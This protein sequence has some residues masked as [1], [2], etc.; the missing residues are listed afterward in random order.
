M[1]RG[2]TNCSPCAVDPARGREQY[3]QDFLPGLGPCA[4]G[5]RLSAADSRFQGRSIRPR[6]FRRNCPLPECKRRAGRYVPGRIRF[7]GRARA[8]I[9]TK[10]RCQERRRLSLQYD[11]FPTQ[12]R[13]STNADTHRPYTRRSY[14]GM[15]RVPFSEQWSHASPC[16][17]PRRDMAKSRTR[18][19]GQYYGYRSKSVLALLEFVFTSRVTAWKS[20]IRVGFSRRL[21]IPFR[22]GFDRDRS[23]PSLCARR[24]HYTCTPPRVCQ[25]SRPLQTAPNLRPHASGARSGGRLYSHV[26]RGHVLSERDGM[27][28]FT[29][30][31]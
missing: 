12:N 22:Q 25:R 21:N 3:R 20:R 2:T 15:G 10:T 23:M 13:S 29:K 7:Q 28:E 31:S 4:V 14:E 18:R 6:Q 24:F 9:R 16:W 17:D 11:I 27:D 5:Y 1:L 19:L 30:R 26:L 8:E